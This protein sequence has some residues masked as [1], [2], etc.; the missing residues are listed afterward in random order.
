M[1]KWAF[2]VLQFRTALVSALHSRLR[3]KCLIFNDIQG[4]KE[5]YNYFSLM[6][7]FNY[8]FSYVQKGSNLNDLC[9]KKI[10]WNQR[11]PIPRGFLKRWLISHCH[12]FNN[13]VSKN[14]FNLFNEK[15]KFSQMYLLQTCRMVQFVSS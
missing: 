8:I 11:L 14:N 6:I 13:P 5:L 4:L 2:L 15:V 9:L 7:Y 3:F 10:K 1:R 12:K